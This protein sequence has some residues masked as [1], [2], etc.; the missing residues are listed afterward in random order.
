MRTSCLQTAHC[1]T[2][3]ATDRGFIVRPVFR[4]EARLLL[5]LRASRCSYR[6]R[7]SF[8]VQHSL[9]LCLQ[10]LQPLNW[11][12]LCVGIEISSTVELQFTPSSHRCRRVALVSPM[13]VYNTHIFL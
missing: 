3:F 1:L 10:F 13:I 8:E 6:W 4:T 9:V 5:K 11:P 12:G 2:V 7:I